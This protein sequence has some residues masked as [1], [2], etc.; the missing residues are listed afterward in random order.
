MDQI[1]RDTRMLGLLLVDRL[2][3]R[4]TLELVGIG[5]VGRQSRYVE[6]DRVGDLRLDVLRVLLRDPLLR[7]EIILHAGAMVQL[8]VVDIHRAQRVDVITLSLG[9]CVQRFRFLDRRKPKRQVS[10]RRWGVRIVEEA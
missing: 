2:E 8:V 9:F 1:V 3:Q 10:R 6:R 5:L 4:S 7:L